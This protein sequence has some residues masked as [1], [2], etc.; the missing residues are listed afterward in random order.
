MHRKFSPEE[1]SEMIMEVDEKDGNGKIELP[2]FLELMRKKMVQEEPDEE[3][4]AAFKQF[5]AEDVESSVTIEKLRDVLAKNG[6]VFT[7]TELNM[8]FDEVAGASEKPKS[9]L[10]AA[11]GNE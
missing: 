2:E 10:D 3:L 1:I 7:E 4:I 9:R 5:G 8:I 11:N 6:E